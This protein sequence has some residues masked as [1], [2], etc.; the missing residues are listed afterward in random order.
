MRIN[1]P[2]KTDEWKELLFIQNIRNSF[3]HSNGKVK[4]GNANLLTYI[5]NS[6]YLELTTN[7]KIQINGG[8]T[9]HCLKIFKDF[10]TVLLS[11]IEDKFNSKPRLIK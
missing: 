8:F 2:S 10:F 7:H 11:R 9:K 3:V 4:T 1:F 5:R 6:T